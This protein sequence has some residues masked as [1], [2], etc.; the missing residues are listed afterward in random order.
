M[1]ADVPRGSPRAIWLQCRRQPHK[2]R[3]HAAAQW[4]V[5]PRFAPLS[6]AILATPPEARSNEVTLGGPRQSWPTAVGGRTGALAGQRL[7]S[8]PSITRQCCLDNMPSPRAYTC[9]SANTLDI[10]TG[11][12]STP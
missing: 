10:T 2:L 11:L 1:C 12:E 4:R 7:A 9:C 3:I 8:T 6:R 5:L